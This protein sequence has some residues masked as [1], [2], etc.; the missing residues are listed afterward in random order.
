MN[1]IRDKDIDLAIV[2]LDMPAPNGFE[3]IKMIK[4]EKKFANLPIIIYTGKENYS[5]DLSKIEGLFE[6]LL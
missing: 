3:L 6:E 4:S 1:L 2:D 5:E